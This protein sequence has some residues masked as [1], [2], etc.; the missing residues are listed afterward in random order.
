MKGRHVFFVQKTIPTSFRFGFVK[1][2]LKHKIKTKNKQKTETWNDEF[3][4]K[5]LQLLGY[6]DLYLFWV[7]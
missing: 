2:K 6:I 4:K 7:T 3:L 1:L 5:T